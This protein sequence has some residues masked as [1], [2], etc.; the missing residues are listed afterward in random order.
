MRLAGRILDR[1]FFGLFVLETGQM[2]KLSHLCLSR[3]K[4]IIVCGRRFTIVYYIS[5]NLLEIYHMTETA[6]ASLGFFCASAT[7][8][9]RAEYVR[10][11]AIVVAPFEFRNIQGQVFAADFV[12]A[13]H[14]A[15]LQERPETVNRLGMNRAINILASTMPHGAM[16]FQLAISWDIRQLRSG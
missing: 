7:R 9:R 3:Q 12:K 11:I 5:V 10:V 1:S 2:F 13:A 4:I 6:S 16:L 8:Y 15:A 14:D